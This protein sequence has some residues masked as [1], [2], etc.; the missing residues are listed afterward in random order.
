M[1]YINEVTR[2]QQLAGINEIRVN[3]PNKSLLGKLII[4]GDNYY[5]E[6]ESGD[7]YGYLNENNLIWFGLIL[8][9]DDLEEEGYPEG[10]DNDNWK[11][12]LG[13]EHTFVKIHNLIGGDILT[14]P[15]MVSISVDPNKLKKIFNK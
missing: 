14:D 2:M 8:D 15:D 4:K 5:I 6:S 9:E 1:K 7:Y 11:D 12:I 13:H 10:F 3:N